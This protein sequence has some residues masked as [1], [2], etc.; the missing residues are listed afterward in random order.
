MRKLL[1]LYSLCREKA[2][3]YLH[4]IV[5]LALYWPHLKIHGKVL[6]EGKFKAKQFFFKKDLLTIELMGN[7]VVGE[8]TI[9]QGTGHIVFG[10]NS[11]CGANCVI[12]VNKKVLIGNHVMIAHAVSIRDTDHVFDDLNIPMAKQGI[13]SDQISIED[14]VWI[15][16]GAIILKGV[17]IGKGSIVAAGAVVTKDVA[18]YSIVGGVPAKLIR[19]R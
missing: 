4:T 13:V 9:I 16:H 14:D 10:M 3:I 17:S 6:F 12:G 8:S 7:N 5:A 1:W 18:P 19:N 11:F 2:S 15:G